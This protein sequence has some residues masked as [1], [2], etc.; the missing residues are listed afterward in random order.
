L[1]I[2]GQI[3]HPLAPGDLIRVQRA[4]GQITLIKSPSK[5]YFEILRTKLKWG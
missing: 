4:S 3:G 5:N 2:D 1:T